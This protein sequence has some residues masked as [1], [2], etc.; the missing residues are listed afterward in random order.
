MIYKRLREEMVR[1]QIEKRG[2]KNPELLQAMREIE[3]HRFVPAGIR[4]KAYGDFPLPIGDGQTISQP[5]IVAFMTELLRVCGTDKV[6]EIGTGSG[7]QT[8]VLARLAGTVV[9]VERIGDL[10]HRAEAL[11]DEMGFG[12]IR[13]VHADGYGGAP[14]FAPY[15]AIVVTCAPDDVPGALVDQLAEGG[16]M[17]VPVGRPGEQTLRFAR[18][19]NGEAQF[20]DVS[21]VRF[22]PMTPG[23][24]N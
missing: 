10:Q 1:D 9:T 15:D 4:E 2:I 22:V 8:A 5:Y 7:Y 12:N 11:L 21:G 19:E 6:L 18:R 20:R 3:R 17:V 14:E 13:Y 24:K 23:I 16:R